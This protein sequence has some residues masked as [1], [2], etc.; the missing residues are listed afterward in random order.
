MTTNRDRDADRP[1]VVDPDGHPWGADVPATDPD[2]P[3]SG[4][5]DDDPVEV[6]E[7]NEPA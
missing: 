4:V 6:P 7:P 3:G 1:D 5:D 2:A